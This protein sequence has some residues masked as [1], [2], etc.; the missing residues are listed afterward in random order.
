MP[1]RDLRVGEIFLCQFSVRE[2][3]IIDRKKVFTPL[4]GTV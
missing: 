1:V 3:H 4:P 2:I